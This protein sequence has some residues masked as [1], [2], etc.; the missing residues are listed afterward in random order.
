MTDQASPSTP[1]GVLGAGS[2]GTALALVL[3]R[4]GRPVRLWGHDPAH[5]RALQRNGENQR[6]LPGAAFPDNLRVTADLAAA[7]DAA[8][9]LL[10]VVPSHAF[11]ELVEQLA[12]LITS[13][14]RIL[15]ATKG[16]DA[17]SGGLLHGIVEQH[18]P[19]RAMGLLSGPSFAREV[20][21]GLPTAVTIASRDAAFARDMAE[22][23]HTGSFRPYT[24]SDLI[25]VELGGAVKNVLAVATGIADG[26]GFGANTRAGLITRG[27]AELGRLGETMGADARTFMGL[28]G[29]GDL[30]LTCTDDQSRNRRLGLALGRGLGLQEAVKQIG[31]TVEGVRT[32]AEVHALSRKRGVE[33]PI[34]DQVHAVIHHGRSPQEALEQ[35]LARSLKDEFE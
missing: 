5:I 4:N 7:V 6:H 18:L 34:S 2:W 13:Q 30:I 29:V 27:L 16:L 24:S 22:A 10:I 17:E 20:V 1:V 32:A 14:A 8:D 26:L 11:R 35:L 19:G 28:S 3:A 25:G 31:Q 15:W 33:M 21:D 23:F 9:D 12:G